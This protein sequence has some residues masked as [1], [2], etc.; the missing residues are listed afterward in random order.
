MWVFPKIMVPQNGWFI[1]E[2]PIRMDDLGYHYFRKHPCHSIKKRTKSCA[3]GSSRQANEL[4]QLQ[5]GPFEATVLEMV[6]VVV[7]F[8]GIYN[9]HVS[10]YKAMKTGVIT[11]TYNL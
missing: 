11:Y 9:S 10:I 6:V 7:V 3:R 1:I 2:N 4:T 5:L 8:G